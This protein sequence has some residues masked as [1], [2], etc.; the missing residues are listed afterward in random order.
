MKACHLT[1]QRAATPMKVMMTPKIM[2]AMKSGD[3]DMIGEEDVSCGIRIEASEKKPGSWMKY[4]QCQV[5]TSRSRA[6]AGT[7]WTEE[8]QQ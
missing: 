7:R 3:R 6:T 8:E 5:C 4:F 1:A 2:F